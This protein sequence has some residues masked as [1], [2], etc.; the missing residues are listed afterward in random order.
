MPTKY[1]DAFKLEDVR[2]Y[3]KGPLG[4]QSIDL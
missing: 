3:L 1:L 2:D 4:I